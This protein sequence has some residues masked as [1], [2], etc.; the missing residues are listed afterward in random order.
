MK[1]TTRPRRRLRSFGA[2]LGVC[3]ALSA[4][5]SA[6]AT[7][8]EV[9]TQPEGFSAE[10]PS[11]NGKSAAEGGTDLLG[12]EGNAPNTVPQPAQVPSAPAPPGQSPSTEQEQSGENTTDQNEDA[13][14]EV[15]ESYF[16]PDFF[17]TNT[18][19]DAETGE[20]LEVISGVTEWQEVAAAASF[21]RALVQ[22]AAA[23]VKDV[24]TVRVSP[25]TG[26]M[27]ST[28]VPRIRLDLDVP[29]TAKTGDTYVLDLNL[30]WVFASSLSSGIE[31]KDARGTVFALL[32]SVTVSGAGQPTRFGSLQVIFTD[33]VETH[34]GI[35][36]FAEFN[37]GGWLKNTQQTI[38]VVV[39]SGATELARSGNWIIPAETAQTPTVSANGGMYADGQPQ[40]QPYIRVAAGRI[41]PAGWTVSFSKLASGLTP[42][43]VG[44]IDH[45][46][47][48]TNG[49]II[50]R[51]ER[52]EATTCTDDFT[53]FVVPQSALSA[54]GASG[55]SLVT[56]RSPLIGKLPATYYTATLNSSIPIRAG[57]NVTSWIVGA[58]TGTP[59]TAGADSLFLKTAKTATFTTSN[60]NPKPTLGDTVTYT[61]T[62]TPGASNNRAITG[63]MTVDKLPV[64]LQFVSASGGGTYNASARTVTWGPRILTSTGKFTDTVTTKITSLPQPR[65]LVNTVSNTADS[66]CVEGDALSTCS[67]SVTTPVGSPDFTF[68]KSSTVEDTNKNGWLGDKGDTIRYGF[69]VTNTGDVS[70]T[71]AMLTDDLL[72][73]NSVACL[74]EGSILKPGA[75]QTCQGT[76]THVITDADVATGSVTNHA[77][78]CVDPKFGLACKPGETTTTTLDPSFEFDKEIE[79]ITTP[80]GSV[81]AEGDVSAGDI[82][83][84]RFVAT[85]TGNTNILKLTVADEMLGV[86]GVDCL[87]AGYV[88]K[89][90]ESLTCVHNSEYDYT[91]TEKDAEQGTVHNIAIGSVPGLP[92]DSGETTTPINPL[93]VDVELPNTGGSGSWIFIGLGAGLF[94]F[95]LALTVL[96]IRKSPTF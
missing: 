82:I 92:D 52:I 59:P 1:Q 41:S 95:G 74:Q 86:S 16:Q 44:Y 69:V 3:L 40:I 79:S 11:N 7:Q 80:A 72:S 23:P 28:N 20:I 50:D 88:M 34:T 8:P 54:I 68:S 93:P 32:K 51:T 25:N 55:E 24:L 47:A 18:L 12:G 78:L 4:S 60:G 58:T 63:L 29:A 31:V 75:S 14:L 76:F 46:G 15:A 37:L 83:R 39:T 62:T 81:V 61:I 33:A 2:A 26:T 9:P 85:N 10:D 36:G 42:S 22:L 38:P 35:K 30:P 17:N 56:F 89:P 57:E 87:P 94:A 6:V 96:H 27:S 13:T 77:T 21:S 65:S 73:L 5:V 43:C 53:K 91:V 64:G 84:F 45:R 48:G 90:A 19:V 70:L 49:F 71:S 66:V 67:A